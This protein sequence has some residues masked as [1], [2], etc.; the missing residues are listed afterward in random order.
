MVKGQLCALEADGDGLGLGDGILAGTDV[1]DHA[2]GPAAGHESAG[3]HSRQLCRV[4]LDLTSVA[5]QDHE[6]R[7]ASEV[8][9]TVACCEPQQTG[10]VAQYAVSPKTFLIYAVQLNT[11]LKQLYLVRRR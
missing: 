9:A 10:Q 6:V 1:Q 11:T 8:A 3:V 2:L 4:V 5:R 7:R